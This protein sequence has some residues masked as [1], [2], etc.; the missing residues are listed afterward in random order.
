MYQLTH[1]F[2]TLADLQAFV[3]AIGTPAAAA[4]AAGKQPPK[5]AKTDSPAAT[6]STAASPPPPAAAPAVKEKAYDQTPIGN[7]LKEA[8]AKG[9]KDAAIALLEK[10]NAKKD[11]KTSGQGLKADQFDAFEAELKVIIETETAD[12]S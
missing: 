3:A 9:K 6:P 11:G 7:M 12:I 1:N 2:A 10:F 5:P 8:V 4:V